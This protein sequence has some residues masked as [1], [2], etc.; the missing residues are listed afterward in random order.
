MVA[1]IYSR[2]LYL[3][4]IFVSRGENLVFCIF[5]VL[6]TQSPFPCVVTHFEGSLKELVFVL[7]GRIPSVLI[8][9]GSEE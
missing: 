4:L 9:R 1:L 3:H 5:I 7:E 8:R 6:K 2:I